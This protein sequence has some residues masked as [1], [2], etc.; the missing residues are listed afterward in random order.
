MQLRGIGEERD[1]LV[2]TQVETLKEGQSHLTNMIQESMAMAEGL[3]DRVNQGYDELKGE[4]Q[5]ML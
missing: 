4:I 3:Y 5:G 2:N 1:R